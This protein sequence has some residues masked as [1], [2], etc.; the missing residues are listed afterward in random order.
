MLQNGD[1][2]IL[3]YKHNMLYISWSN[4]KSIKQWHQQKVDQFYNKTKYLCIIKAS[5]KK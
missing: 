5:S 1:N 3:L 2:N 4:N